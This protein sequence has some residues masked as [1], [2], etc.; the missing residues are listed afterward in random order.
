MKSFRH[1]TNE[2]N[3]S[4]VLKLRM[5]HGAAGYGIY[6]MLLERIASEPLQRAELDY[7]VLAYD[8]HESAELIRSVV[9][10]FDLFVIDIE[11]ET[12]SHEGLNNQLSAKAKRVKQEK[13]L[14]EFISNQLSDI[15][16]INGLAAT[17]KTSPD[18][19]RSLFRGPF[20]ER[21]LSIY[22]APPSSFTLIGALNSF[23]KETLG[24]QESGTYH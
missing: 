23:I 2:R 14:D 6:M 24:K 15:K 3:K 16:C 13:L 17:Y 9:E 22:S 18:R 20:R 10:D 12:F 11:T 5:K 1:S 8:F 19:I 21:I 4:N 7:E